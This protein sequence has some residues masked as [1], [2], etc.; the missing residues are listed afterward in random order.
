MYT[1][2]TYILDEVT[3][4]PSKTIITKQLFY[5]LLRKARAR[6]QKHKMILSSPLI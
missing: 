3:T 6:K 1:D 2:S 4:L 5:A